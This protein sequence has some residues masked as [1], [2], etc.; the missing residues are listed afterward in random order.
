MFRYETTVLGRAWAR[1][2]Q[3][4]TSE[5]GIPDLTIRNYVVEIQIN[6]LQKIK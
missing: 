5:R 4:S 2:R 1:R 6:T 3:I